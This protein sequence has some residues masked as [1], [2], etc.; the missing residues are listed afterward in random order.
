MADYQVDIDVNVDDSKLDALEKRIGALKN[1][2]VEVNAKLTGDSLKSLNNQI[3]SISKGKVFRIGADDSGVKKKLSSITKSINGTKSMKPIKLDADTSAV[4]RKVSRALKSVSN[5]SMKPIKVSADTSSA[6]KNIES[7]NAIIK[8]GQAN[9]SEFKSKMK[10]FGFNDKQIDNF[11]QK[12]QNLNVKVESLDAGFKDDHTFTISVKGFDE[13]E[14]KIQNV[15]TYTKQVRDNIESWIPSSNTKIRLFEDDSTKKTN[16]AY[17]ELLSTIKEIG[18][19]KV[20]LAGLDEASEDVKILS[21]ELTRL[22]SHKDNLVKDYGNRFTGL[23]KNNIEAVGAKQNVNVNLA[24]AKASIKETNAAYKELVSTMKE[25]GSIRVQLQGLDEGSRQAEKLTADLERLKSNAHNIFDS[26][27]FNESQMNGITN[28]TEKIDSDLENAKAKIADAR[29]EAAK[30]IKLNFDKGGIDADFGKIK[31][32]IYSLGGFSEQ[33]SSEYQDVIAKSR[34]LEAAIESG[35]HNRAIKANEDYLNSL[36]RLEN[37]IE[38]VSAKKK[39]ADAL[40]KSELAETQTRLKANNLSM[41]IESYL[42]SNTK[43]SSGFVAELREIQAQLQ[44]CDA[45]QLTNLNSQV[46]NVQMR[47]EAAGQSGLNFVDRLK[48]QF[49]RLAGYFGASSVIYGGMSVLRNMA[50]NVLDVDTQM[51]E[52]KRVTDLSSSQYTELYDNMIS[53]AKEYGATLSDIISSTAD[54]SRAG[55]D[56]NTANRLSEITMMYE[57]IADI[58]Y[59][60]ATKNLLTTYKGFQ[61]QLDGTY[62]D[63]ETS[64]GHITDVLNELDNNYSVTASGVGEAL[65]RSAASMDVANNSFEQTAALVTGAVEVTQDPEGAGNALKVVSMR[66]RGAKGELEELGEDVDDNVTNLT[67][68]QGQILNLTHGKVNIF[69]DD[70]SFKS[71]YEI[72]QGIY[73]VWDDLSDIEQGDLLETI[74]GK[75]RANTVASILGNFGN[76]EKSYESALNSTGSAAK[77][78]EKYMNSLQGRL[79]NLTTVFQSFSNTVMSSNFLKGFVDAGSGALNVLDNMIERFK[80]LPTLLGLV[81]AA[82]SPSGRGGLFKVVE[83]SDALFGKKITT[84][85]GDIKSFFNDKK[86]EPIFSSD[87]TSKL[88]KDIDSIK[89]YKEAISGGSISEGDAFAQYMDGTS[90]LAKE[91]VKNLDSS[92]ISTKE[93]EKNQ[94]AMQVTARASSKTFSSSRSLIKEY[95]DGLKN[96]GLSVDEFMNATSL[97][98]S[99]LAKYFS[100]VE[101]GKAS[102][103]GYIA[104]ITAAKVASVGLQ[105]ATMALNMGLTMIVSTLVSAGVSAFMD[106]INRAEKL[107]ETVEEATTSYEQQHKTLINGKSDFEDL[108]ESYGKL[109]SGVDKFTGK[110]ISLM[111][112]EYKEYQS[113]VNQ[114][115]DTVPSLV[116]GY[117][118]QGNAILN[119]AGDVETLT[120]AYND[121]IIAENNKLI[122][123]DGKDYKGISDLSKD[124]KNDYDK[125]QDRGFTNWET[126]IDD[127][128]ALKGL[129]EMTD[130]T[131]DS[132]HEYIA[133]LPKDEQGNVKTSAFLIGRSLKEEIEKQNLDIGDIEMPNLFA[134]NDDWEKFIA[135]VVQKCP[136]AAKSITS[137]FADSL[138][139][140]AA[141]LRKA[142]NAY[143]ENAFLKGD[144]SN[145][146]SGMQSI[147]SSMISGLDSQFINQLNE[148]GGEEA[149]T[150]WVDNVLGSLN[151]LNK[152][153]RE[154][155]QNAFNLGGDFS[156]GEM[157]FGEYKSQLKEVS[158]I[159]DG[160]NLDDESKHQLKLSLNID[161]VEEQ[162]E[163]LK[164]RL[165][166]EDIKM[167]SKAAEDFINSLSSSELKSV[168]KLL[169]EG[170]VEWKGKS[171]DE[172]KAEIQSLA[173]VIKA[174]NFN[175][176]IDAE[177]ESL[178]KFNT[179][180]AESKTATGLTAD[181]VNALKSRYKGLD[182]YNQASLF[183][184]TANGIRLNTQEYTKLEQAYA[185]GK[186]GEVTDNINTLKNRYD[187]LTKSIAQETDANVIANKVAEQESIRQKINDL[188]E[189]AAQYEGLASKYNAWQNAESAGSDRDMYENVLKGFDEVKGEL[190]RGWLDD[191]SKAFID[192]F[193]YDQLNSIDDYTNRFKTLGDTID[194]TTYSVKDF[195]TQNENGESTNDGVY[196]FL[197]AV[198]QLGQG[199]IKRDENGE[200]ISFD[201]GVNGEDAIAKTMGISKELVQIIERAAEDAGFVI[202]MDGTYTNFADLQK[203]AV[204]SNKKINELAQSSEK[205]KKLGLDNYTFHFD[206]TDAETVFNDLNKAKEMLDTF[207]RD[208]G[209]IDLSVP[210]AQDAL[211]IAKTLQS[212]YDKLSDPVYM[213]LDTSQVDDSMKKPLRLMQEYRTEQKKLNQAKLQGADTSEIDKSMSDIVDKMAALDDDT[214]VKLGIDVDASKED[215]KKQLDS[216]EL[217]VDATVDLQVEANDTLNDIKLLLK[218]QAGL[219]NDD[220]LR[221]GLALDTSSVD[222]YT[223]EDATKIVKFLP[224]NPDFLDNLGLKDDKKKVVVD[225]V[226][227]NADFLNG[228][229]LKDGEKEILLK[230]VAENPDLLKDL[231][232]DQK[233]VAIDFVVNNQDILNKI[234]DEKRR[235]IV[236]DFVAKNEG[237]FDDLKTD[238]EKEIAVNFITNNESVLNGLENNQ[239][240]KVIIDFVAKNPNFFDDLGLDGDKKKIAIDFVAKNQDLLKDLDYGKKKQ[241]VQ[242]VANYENWGKLGETQQDKVVNFIAN[243]ENWG[244]LDE[245]QQSRVV[246]LVANYEGFEKLDE[247]KKEQVVQF[248]AKYEGFDQLN[249]DQ[250]QKVVDV[251]V[252][253]DNWDDMSFEDKKAKIDYE[254]GKT[255]DTVPDASGNA[256]FEVGNSPDTVNDA[257][258]TA[259]YTLGNSPNT[260]N[261]AS[262][263]ANY[264]L[265]TSPNAV[266]PVS[267]T[268]N[269]TLG[270]SP[271]NVPSA[272]GMANFALGETPLF[273]PDISGNANYNGTFPT[274]APTIFGTIQYRI[275]TIGEALGSFFGIGGVD[276]TAH[277]QGTAYANGTT[278]KAFKQGNWGTKEDGVAL[279]GELGTELLVRNGR[280]YTIGENGAEFFGY[281]KDDI[282]FN[283]DQTKELFEKGKITHGN[284]R[285]KALADGTAFS[286]GSGGLGRANK[287]SSSSSSSSSYNS[288]NSGSSSSS[289]SSSA[290]SSPSSD[291]SA[292]E[293]AE[294]FEETL[295]W[296]ETAID[297]I[298]RAISRLDKTASSTYKK[299][300]KRNS[301]LND[302]ISKTREEID[303]QQRAYDRY[304]QQANSV[305]LDEGYASKVRNGTID[306]EV[307]TDEDLNDKISQY[308]EW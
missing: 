130:I 271:S 161:G 131:S 285:G 49:N 198:D 219:I 210:G 202:N 144:Y 113:V 117:D 19:V 87:F 213:Q 27:T 233:K 44:A 162:Y 281:K 200:I 179:A 155:F 109:S 166:S 118:A 183:E 257:S 182:G 72:L 69:E 67:K 279:G 203:A 163:T 3:N 7:F 301:A 68:M 84:T 228:L 224:E 215:I 307:I 16:A 188:G 122:N 249:S 111:P 132:V 125:L 304:I 25:I 129:M 178:E 96:C 214:K 100:T 31:K 234:D 288:S 70:G 297:R 95:N 34:E 104:Q 133:N 103:T 86:V 256:N 174:E 175:I 64:V 89:K 23:Q 265:G 47:V 9:I 194:G 253:T 171:P 272:S 251:I 291:S 266:G 38:R 172:I 51:T 48:M 137:K 154:K 180:L 77:E 199:N 79:N 237:I 149:L 42:R 80:L 206:S 294:K 102:F 246:N 263:T 150:G 94:R 186:L 274:K 142:M 85:F 1:K 152:D 187:E 55:F 240:R 98:N 124:L 261:D 235:K 21:N 270:D 105:A 116:A 106:W 211:N 128:N 244:Q 110:N 4:E 255:P 262:G 33:V 306:I 54:W 168:Q 227:D 277:A 170:Q 222:D 135:D 57:H 39:K 164:N 287:Y 159:I 59:E 8:N 5:V 204:E 46:K 260:V 134:S 158:N 259:N 196:N 29:A 201:F 90:Q 205:L 181:S 108:A 97:G 107:K 250:M 56:P 216:G 289:S 195:F 101:Q 229:D 252:N 13:A 264:T 185:K 40:E 275:Q 217:T 24:Q 30:A 160:M 286:R 76:V 60:E 220:Q 258:G 65:R 308:K 141:D 136:E 114:I 41:S 127:A 2:D 153:V 15:T 52:L 225:F 295:D 278:G 63:T 22:E 20:K 123:G 280:W 91:Y 120:D 121:L 243:Y 36:N 177:T 43:M 209:T 32:S 75:H 148:S 146:D 167:D 218:H 302:Q 267:G 189:L 269:Y 88:S 11:A 6:E 115:A 93:F 14:R 157:S 58:D 143:L 191:A 221:I 74:A 112:D 293:E 37:E 239:Q 207:R 299:W 169:V 300:H 276:G 92:A 232:E 50:T 119:C 140:G 296:I 283:A 82:L 53:S 17:K 61:K 231:N 139:D 28:M 45:T 26:N 284:G 126:N 151:N 268:A 12:L 81:S 66:L 173:N 145:L 208:D 245:T 292:N 212:A 197:E 303:M 73:E 226:S 176:D 184:E 247:T 18:S 242:F 230:Y 193:S 241:V 248:A 165:T 223:K 238:E 78:N 190:S 254:L 290:N 83:D 236:V 282:I 305:G 298:E 138:D 35:D 10:D 71:T 156:K 147:V 192:L 62:G 99:S 273:A